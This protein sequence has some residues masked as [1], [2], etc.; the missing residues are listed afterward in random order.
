[1]CR[2]KLRILIAA[3]VLCLVACSGET[4]DAGTTYVPEVASKPMVERASAPASIDAVAMD[5]DNL[6]FT[7]EDGWIYRLAKQGSQPPQKVASFPGN[8]AWGIAVDASFVYVTALANGFGGGVVVRAPK[9]G[10]ESTT[11]AAGQSRPWGIAVDDSQ[12]YWVEQGANPYDG[13]NAAGGLAE[14]AILALSKSVSGPGTPAKL[15][16]PDVKVGD[17]VA[18]DDQ[19]V[20]WHETESV[21]RVPKVGGAISTLTSSTVPTVSSN[22]IVQSGQ[23]Y[24]AEAVAGVWSISSV[25]ATGGASVPLA[26]NIAQPSSIA[27]IGSTLF[28]SDAQGPSVGAIRS[29]PVAGGNQTL[30]SAPNADGSVD[31]RGVSFVLVDASTYYTV[32]FWS[33]PDLHVVIDEL[34]R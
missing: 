34:P 22:L 8:Y 20:Y 18:V 27:L 1:M 19:A 25:P 31:G 14:G 15:L 17:M 21:R 28:W 16:A 30:T 6:Y 26:M 3:P 13:E 10:G 4:L 32:Q 9:G 7:C 5:E 29:V 33:Q 23:V 11:L 12:V 2:S 24:W